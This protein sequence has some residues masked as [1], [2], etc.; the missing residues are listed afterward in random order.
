M[1]LDSSR[2]LII[3]ISIDS[4]LSFCVE[5][6]CQKQQ[7]HF[8]RSHFQDFAIANLSVILIVSILHGSL[9]SM[10]FGIRLF[11]LFC[12]MKLLF[13]STTLS[14]ENNRFPLYYER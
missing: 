12:I 6:D 3:A 2:S 14:L 8:L 10:L 11:S 1:L 13:N 5:L 4:V 9:Y 7:A